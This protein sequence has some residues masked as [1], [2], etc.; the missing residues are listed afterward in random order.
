MVSIFLFRSKCS[1]YKVAHFNMH[2]Y[3]VNQTFG[4][5]E[6]IWLLRQSRQIR[7]FSE[8]TYFTTYVRNMF[9]AAILYKYY[10]SGCLSRRATSAGSGGRGTR[11]TP[12]AAGRSCPP[13]SA[14]SEA[15]GTT[16]NMPAI[17]IIQLLLLLLAICIFGD[18]SMIM[19][20]FFFSSEVVSQT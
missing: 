8:N 12:T 10:G 17:E 16:R 2:T 13:T 14:P 15:T 1:Y 9:W 11:R 5:V 3:G 4:L 6:G 19:Y 20:F 7:F 18:I